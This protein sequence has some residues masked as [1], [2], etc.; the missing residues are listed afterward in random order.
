[1]T[2]RQD[3]ESAKVGGLRRVAALLPQYDA[4]LAMGSDILFM[5]F[6]IP[7]DAL[8]QPGDSVVMSL[9]GLGSQT[10]A[11]GYSA[12][13]FSPINNDLVIWMRC[14][15]T[16]DFLQRLIRESPRWLGLRFLWQQ[17]LAEL[18]LAGKERV[19]GVRFAPH[20]E[21][22]SC[23]QPCEAQYQM[24]DFALHL[25]A[26]PEPAKVMLARQMSLQA[27]E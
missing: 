14:D 12:D 8:V 20:R 10:G 18:Y 3:W 13:G 5:N 24:G 27:I 11:P 1:M 25:L 6:S 26:F 15:E 22:Q 23:M 4:V 17:W 9:E 19:N 21:L 2:E 7:L 16:A